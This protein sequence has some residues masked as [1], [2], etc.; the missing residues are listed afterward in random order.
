[1]GPPQASV[2]TANDST[3]RNVMDSMR[4]FK[5]TPECLATFDDRESVMNATRGNPSL[6]SVGKTV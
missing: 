3:A 6:G 2:L 4:K 5:R 1:M